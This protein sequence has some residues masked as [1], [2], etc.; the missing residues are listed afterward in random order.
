MGLKDILSDM[1]RSAVDNIARF[2]ENAANEVTVDGQ[3]Y[4]DGEYAFS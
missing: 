1:N 2:V 4:M 3:R